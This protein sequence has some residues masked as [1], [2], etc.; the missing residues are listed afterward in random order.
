MVT[1]DKLKQYIASND[2]F[3]RS[4]SK[5]PEIA[6]L[7]RWVSIQ[8]ESYKCK[9]DLMI[10]QTIR[11]QWESFIDCYPLVFHAKEQQW[12]ASLDK[13]VE[14]IASKHQLPPSNSKDPAVKQL[15]SWVNKQ[16]QKF[17][18]QT[19]I[20]KSRK[21]M[22]R[23]K[24]FVNLHP[25]LFL[26]NEQQWMVMLDHLKQY[27]TSNDQL[28]SS[29][30][31]DPT[32]KQLASWVYKQKQNYKKQTEI[33][34]SLILRLEWEAMMNL[35]PQLFLTK[36]Q[37]WM[38]TLDKLKQYIASEQRLPSLGSKDWMV[39]KLGIWVSKQKKNYRF[40]M[41]TMKNQT[42]RSQWETMMNLHSKLF[43][44]SSQQWMVTFV[45]LQRYF[46]ATNHLP[47]SSSKD[48]KVKQLA[49]WV[50]KQKQN[51]KNQTEI[52]KNQT[53][54]AQWEAFLNRYP[55]L[56]LTSEEQ[57][58]ITLANLKQYVACNDQLPQWSSQNVTVKKLAYWVSKQKL[59]YKMRTF[60]MKD[61]TISKQWEAFEEENPKLFATIK[62]PWVAALDSVE[63][64]IESNDHLPFNILNDPTV[65]Q[66][67]YRAPKFPLVLYIEI[68]VDPFCRNFN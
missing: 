30:S 28:P 31:K 2:Q 14:Y 18:M 7:G 15:S 36:E 13:L 54:L 29:Y 6:K 67:P 40:E 17:K 62:P 65:S 34:K 1:L 49:S 35:Y 11:V 19:E 10:N 27:M 32:V 16:K 37:Q 44:T 9:T 42:I 4:Y 26:T 46:A 53:I 60:I 68:L 56:F 51:Y 55:Q 3:P 64:Y 47:P 21:I 22:M 61:E 25:S 45:S 52:M 5:E 43:L 8:K 39:K 66:N 33:M 59:Q 63:Q 41:E 57:W 38:A 50:S 23:W 58:M 12:M 48:P 24:A 20:M